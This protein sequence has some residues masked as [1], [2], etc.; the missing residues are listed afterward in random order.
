MAPNSVQIFHMLSNLA[1]INGSSN[2]VDTIESCPVILYLDL[3][4]IVPAEQ[5]RANLPNLI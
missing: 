4:G 3:L 1:T 5:Q 2:A